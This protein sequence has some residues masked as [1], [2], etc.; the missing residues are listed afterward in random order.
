MSN[1]TD[2]NVVVT[3][4]LASGK[5]FTAYDVTRIVRKRRAKLGLTDYAYHSDVKEA[6]HNQMMFAGFMFQK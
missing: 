6:V 4:L 3:E 1:V 2:V 5:M